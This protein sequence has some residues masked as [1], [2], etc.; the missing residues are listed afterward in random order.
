MLHSALLLIALGSRCCV[1]G[2]GAESTSGAAPQRGLTLKTYANT[3][4]SGA[5]ATTSVV[6][7]AACSVPTGGAPLSA[8]LVGTISFPAS[9]GVFHFNCSWVGT[10]V[11]FVWMDGHMVCQD[12]HAYHPDSGSTDNPL[13][14]NL[15]PGQ[16]KGVVSS[17]PFRAHLY[18]SGYE[19]THVGVNVTWAAL[20]AA[21]HSELRAQAS[22]QAAGVTD[23]LMGDNELGELVESVASQMLQ[24]LPHADLPTASLRTELPAAEQH[25]DKLQRGLARGWGSWLHENMLPVVKLPEAVVV[26]PALCSKS[27]RRCIESCVPDG[28]R[29]YSRQTDPVG[30]ET[31]VGHHAYDRSYVQFYFGGGV[32]PGGAPNVSLEY[33]ASA[34]GSLSL[35]LTAQEANCGGNCSDWEVQLYARYAWLKAGGANATQCD[36]EHDATGSGSSC[37]KID[38]TPAGFPPVS[39]YSTGPAVAGPVHGAQVALSA[40]FEG[41]RPIGFST[42]A[43]FT[44]SAIVTELRAAKEKEEALL[45]QTFGSSRADT[46]Q[47]IQASVMWNLHS[48]PAENGGAPL[49]PVSRVWGTRGLC[50][51][52]GDW[53]YIIFDWDN[54]F[55]SLLAANGANSS[56][57]GG[58]GGMADDD[59][60]VGYSDGFGIAVSNLIQTVKAK[61]ASGFVP[62]CAAGG[63]KSQDRSEPPVGARVALQLLKKFGGASYTTREKHS[64]PAGS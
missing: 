34:D 56:S 29:P 4:L 57:T 23:A 59:P 58:N 60:S 16:T 7:A 5:P 36:T 24:G 53:A 9:G 21:Q 35:L 18:Y 44:T 30:V 3:A 61:T 2:A 8:E 32:T 22:T 40:S 27:T 13:S 37:G 28:T 25:R 19:E 33:S 14:I 41:G 64:N 26:A 49:L 45:V 46:G 6:T 31:R 62:N 55:A 10:T 20:S 42:N 1:H 50:P 51:G 12:G 15:L 47:A 48:A 43:T 63:M 54:L 11:G 17:L 39:I 52:V 38:F